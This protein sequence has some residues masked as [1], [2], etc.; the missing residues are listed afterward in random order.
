MKV[1][2]GAG[3][4]LCLAGLMAPQAHAENFCAEDV[5]QFCSTVKPGAG[6]VSR[7]LRDHD[8][9]LSARC[10]AKL[11]ADTERAKAI[12]E[13]FT[14]ACTTD[15]GRFC[16][17]VTM[18]EGRI[19]KCLGQHATGLSDRCAGE[20]TKFEEGREKMLAVQNAC[21]SDVVTLCPGAA[22]TAS[23]VIDCLETN[24]AKLSPECKA[25]GPGVAFQAAGLV[26]AMDEITSQAR[27][28]DTIGIL[29]GLDS[30]AFSRN[31]IA[32]VYDYFQG[33]AGEPANANRFTFNPLFVFGRKNEFAIQLKVPVVALFPTA[34]GLPPVSGVAD[35]NTAFAWAFYSRGSIRQYLAIGLQWNSSS[36]A[37]VGAPWV[38]VPVYAIVL[39]LGKWASLTLQATY[40]HSIGH[41]GTYPGV[42]FVELRPIFVFNLP[43][44]T[45]VSVDT[46]LGWDFIKQIFVPVMKFQ[47]GKLIGR[48]RDVSIAAWYQLS[49]TTQ[50]RVDSFDFGV[51][52]N[53]SYFFDW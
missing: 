17:N 33:L 35:L 8:D 20:I 3:L 25:A 24:E 18:G 46:K 28:S 45:F 38:I 1:S 10:K 26:D 40:S 42:N 14:Y 11:E 36:A 32:F 48:D 23:G 16:S 13:D 47:A 53:L 34:A 21:K 2:A 7:C 27:I 29:Q 15:I 50:G 22:S 6:N 39:G 19:Y 5:K 9:K 52:V 49:L 4:T 37:L 30:I 41:L 44:A 43:D 31:Q 51:G 12:I